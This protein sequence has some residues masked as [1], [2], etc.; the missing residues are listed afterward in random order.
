VLV[1]TGLVALQSLLIVVW[2]LRLRKLRAERALKLAEADAQR[3]REKVAHLARVAI[4][5]QMS[6]ALAHELNQPLT[7]ILSNAQAAQRLIARGRVEDLQPILADIVA[8]NTR[9]G[10]VIERLRAL[11]R[12]GGTQLEPLDVGALLTDVLTLARGQLAAYDVAVR[13]RLAASLPPVLGDRVQL[14]QVLLNLLLNA[15]EAMSGNERHDRSLIA[16]TGSNEH[17]F[18][19]I[20]VA[21]NGSGIGPDVAAH[22]FEPF[23]TTKETGL[24]LGLSICRSIMAV[25]GG[26]IS[27][28]NNSDR[29]ATFTVTLPRA[30]Q[31]PYARQPAVQ[32]PVA[33]SGGA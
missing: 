33:S 9:A 27:A 1:I 19:T 11:L 7:A 21:D 25:H 15:I 6:G 22:L 17:G 23:V 12:K 31:K 18:V 29:G 8:D 32:A 24:G 26:Q 16:S 10:E 13:T 5:G 28:V 3:Q 4:L 20:T 2:L 30:V 14:Q